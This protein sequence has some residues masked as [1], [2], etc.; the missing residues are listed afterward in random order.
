M[1][2]TALQEG[3][4]NFSLCHGLS[5][6][7][8]LLLCGGRALGGEY[9]HKSRLAFQVAKAAFEASRR[10]I[11][12]GD[13]GHPDLMA[14]LAGVGYFYL[15]LYNPLIPSILML[16][17]ED[18]TNRIV[19]ITGSSRLLQTPRRSARSGSQF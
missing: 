18:F 8:E 1:I 3:N 7:A 11:G 19:K 9:I 14:G 17:R 5:G 15:R 2:A 13:S 12:A 16:R 6:N 10:K 4:S